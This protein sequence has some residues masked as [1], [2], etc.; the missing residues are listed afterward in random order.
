MRSVIIEANGTE[1]KMK[2][3]FGRMVSGLMGEEKDHYYLIL[4]MS[5]KELRNFSDK[6]AE[7]EFFRWASVLNEEIVLSIWKEGHVNE[8]RIIRI[9]DTPDE[10]ETLDEVKTVYEWGLELAALECEAMQTYSPMIQRMRNI[11]I[12]LCDAKLI[13]SGCPKWWR[14]L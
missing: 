13:W 10:S 9:N 3:K 12:M 14:Q 1:V 5:R 11:V 4:G 7:I 2:S 6:E 8:G